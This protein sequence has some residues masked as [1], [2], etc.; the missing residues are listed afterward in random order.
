MNELSVVNF[1]INVIEIEIDRK[2]SF[3]LCYIVKISEVF[4]YID[5]I[6]LFILIIEN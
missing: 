2:I 1:E 6:D 4:R 3:F 5:C